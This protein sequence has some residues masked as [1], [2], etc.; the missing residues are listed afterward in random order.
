LHMWQY[1]KLNVAISASS[2][3]HFWNQWHILYMLPQYLLELEL[4]VS[5]LCCT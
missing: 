2:L 4:L 5:H 3:V 1:D